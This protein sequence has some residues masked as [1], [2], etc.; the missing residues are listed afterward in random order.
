MHSVCV[1]FNKY[2]LKNV[3]RRYDGKTAFKLMLILAD[4]RFLTWATFLFLF[5]FMLRWPEFQEKNYFNFSSDRDKYWLY[6]D[7]CACL[8]F[9]S[10]PRLDFAQK[11]CSSDH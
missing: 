10:V 2:I 1:W 5:F 11:D 4:W 7:F 9:F 8:F 3:S 6:H